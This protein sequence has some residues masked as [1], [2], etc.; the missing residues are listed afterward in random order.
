MSAT[1]LS[2]PNAA[3]P[4]RLSS[5][6][7]EHANLVLTAIEPTLEFLKAA[8]PEWRVR[9]EG[10]DEWSG[11]KRRWLHFGDDDFFI[12]LNDNGAGALRDLDGHE[13]GLAHLGFVVASLD[14]TLAR[15]ARAGYEPDHRGPAHPHRRNAYFTEHGLEFEF[16]E[17]LSD[18][19]AE[20]NLY[21]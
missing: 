15:L 19:P 1:V 3:A 9:G 2:Q 21:V 10:R 8:F 4:V 16:V 11:K 12:T 14:R 17:Y 13:P 7:L 18:D 5:P 6:R 20:R